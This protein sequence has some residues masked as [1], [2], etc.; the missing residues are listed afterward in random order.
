MIENFEV[1][2]AYCE[3]YECSCVT[4]YDHH[5]TQE[6]LRKHFCWMDRVIIKKMKLKNILNK[7]IR[8]LF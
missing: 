3:F 6:E 1:W 8:K 5:P 7:P 4:I 2:V